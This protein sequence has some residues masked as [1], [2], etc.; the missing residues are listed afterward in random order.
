MPMVCCSPVDCASLCLCQAW[1]QPLALVSLPF[2]MSM[3]R[4][5]F[6]CATL[7]QLL[8]DMKCPYIRNGKI[9]S[10]PNIVLEGHGWY[11][12]DTESGSKVSSP[13]AYVWVQFRSKL[14]LRLGRGC[15]GADKPVSQPFS[16][17]ERW[18]EYWKQKDPEVGRYPTYQ[19]V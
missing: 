4:S 11:W 13:S 18:Q 6:H 15:E 1:K 10:R 8:T 9:L 14:E 19:T 3:V 17:R 5:G 16:V 12:S 2:N 7:L